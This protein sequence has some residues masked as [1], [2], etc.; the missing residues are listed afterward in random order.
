[1]PEVERLLVSAE[2]AEV[3]I[4]PGGFRW[5]AIE[6]ERSSVDGFIPVYSWAIHREHRGASHFGQGSDGAFGPSIV[7]CGTM[8]GANFTPDVVF[9]P[10][11][12]EV[13]QGKLFGS[14]CAN[15]VDFFDSRSCLCDSRS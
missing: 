12:R 11:T 9:Y 1:M 5:R 4:V 7:F 10:E 8:W 14:I 6:C 2:P 3:N 15:N 13:T